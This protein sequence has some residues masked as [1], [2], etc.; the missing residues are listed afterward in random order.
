MA[1]TAP[2]KRKLVLIRLVFRVFDVIPLCDKCATMQVALSEIETFMCDYGAHHSLVIYPYMPLIIFDFDNCLAPGNS[3]GE[4][5]LLPLFDVIESDKSNDLTPSMRQE[6]RLD[7]W[8]KPLD[9][10]VEK[11]KF[12]E[13]SKSASYAYFSQ[14]SIAHPIE[15]YEDTHLVHAFEGVKLLV[16]SGFQKFQHSKIRQ[17]GVEGAFEDIYYD[18][19]GNPPRKGKAF[20]FDIIAK[21]YNTAPSEVWVIGDSE[22]SEI[23]AGNSLGMKTVQILRQGVKK[24]PKAQFHVSSLQE[25]LRL[26][27]MS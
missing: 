22:E 23:S 27:Q 26:L 13:H 5:I 8:R 18:D 20:Y 15:G 17:L 16:T 1:L 4:D 9:Y 25:F 10:I 19:P 2:K 6:M 21:K 3:V 11:Y 14:L 7:F 24:S 12:S